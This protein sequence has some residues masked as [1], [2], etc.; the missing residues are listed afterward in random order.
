MEAGKTAEDNSLSVAVVAVIHH[1]REGERHEKL[2]RCTN[3]KIQEIMKLKTECLSEKSNIN[4]T[5]LREGMG[6]CPDE[7]HL[8]DRGNKRVCRRL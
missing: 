5:V 2:Q 3:H 1:P 6:C 8:N 7:V 4:F